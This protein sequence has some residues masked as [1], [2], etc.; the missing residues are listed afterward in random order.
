MLSG[1]P[2]DYRRFIY[3]I[4]PDV[5]AAEGICQ[6]LRSAIENKEQAK[7]KYEDF[8]RYARQNLTSESIARTI[9]R[10]SG[11]EMDPT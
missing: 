10:L 6:A 1:M 7:Q 5:T 4:S 3:E 2:E 8:C 9:L 11:F